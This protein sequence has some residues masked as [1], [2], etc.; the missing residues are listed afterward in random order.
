MFGDTGWHI[1]WEQKTPPVVL[2]YAYARH[3]LV[4]RGALYMDYSQV[5]LLDP[6][7]RAA[8]TSLWGTGFGWVATMGPNWEARLLFSFPLLDAGTV[9]AGEP[10]F[11]F[12][13]GAQF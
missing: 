9:Q 4:V 13:L 8:H 12:S 1:G 7:G 3:P 2:G 5:G 11:D 6:Q 10:R